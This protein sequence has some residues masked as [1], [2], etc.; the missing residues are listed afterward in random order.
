VDVSK[1]PAQSIKQ[2]NEL[3]RIL[4]REA[5]LDLAARLG[6]GVYGYFIV[7]VLLWWSTRYP[8][9]HAKFFWG[10]LAFTGFGMGLRF[11]LA[12]LRVKVYARSPRLLHWLQILSVVLGSGAAG[13][14][15]T[16]TLWFY[17]FES[18]TFLVVLL[19]MS[20]IVAGSG[21]SFTP[22]RG[23]MA[24][25]VGL[26]LGPV[27]VQCLFIGGV[28]GG[29]FAVLNGCFYLFMLLLGN[30]LHKMYWKMLEDRFLESARAREL[31]LAKQ[32][33]EAA[34]LAKSNFLANTSHEIRTPMHGILGMAQLAIDAE[35]PQE[36]REHLRT[37]RSCTQGLLNV[38]N[39]ILDFSKIEAGKLTLETIA[40][41]LRTLV[42]DVRAIIQ[43]LARSRGLALECSVAEG[44][45]DRLLGDPTR[46]RQVLINLM[47]NATKFTEAGSVKLVVTQSALTDGHASVHFEVTDSG[48]GIAPEH[49]EKIFEAFT[50]AEGSVGRR[51]GGTGLGLSISSE[52]V[53][54]MG[55]RLAV[56]STPN[57]GS[58]FYFTCEFAVAEQ[59][60]APALAADSAEAARSLRI[61]VAED[62]PVNQ[63]LVSTLLRKRGHQIRAVP[64][65]IAAVQ[66]CE[67]ESFDLILMDDQMPGMSGVEATRRIRAQEASAGKRTRIIA[68]TA[69]VTLADR[70]RLMSAGMDGYLAKP[71][72]AEELYATI[73][74]SAAASRVV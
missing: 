41:P 45:P 11:A 55:G 42:D 30:H 31:E 19:W 38:L 60:E 24:L 66:A 37:L 22:S 29:T 44:I 48:I 17:G 54:L 72:S 8:I 33:A 57:V 74:H 43:P 7:F 69:N 4:V 23:M 35:T 32:S 5:D 64:T 18:W 59:Q 20:G 9:E 6:Y 65:G 26:L 53:H 70:E 3:Q 10:F 51:F 40:F 36:S 50:Q 13:L 1:P 63:M 2:D 25:H 12:I 46:L 34:N 49:Q 28:R 58:T 47:G 16:N 67:A 52:L 21:L 71:F 62:N 73:G 39:D 27:C 14:L 15:I 61:M 68:L 56:R